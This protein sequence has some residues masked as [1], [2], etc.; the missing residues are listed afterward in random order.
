MKLLTNFLATTGL[1][2]LM[3]L[4]AC[5]GAGSLGDD[6]K[7]TEVVK[8]ALE[9]SQLKASCELNIDAFS[10][11]L[12]ANIS[13]E[14]GP[15]DCLDKTLDL[16]IRVVETS[17]P[18]SLSRVALENYLLKNQNDFKAEDIKMVKAVFDI[19]HLIFGD[20]PDYISK[21]NKN[22]IIA[23]AKVFNKE[24]S[25]HYLLFE[26]KQEVAYAVH[27]EVHL[28]RISTSANIIAKELLNIFNPNRNRAVHRINIVKLLESFTSD[29]KQDNTIEKAKKLLFVKRLF[30]GG[31]NEEITHEELYRLFYHMPKLVQVIFDI[32][33]FEYITIDQKNGLQLLKTDLDFVNDIIYSNVLG[34][35]E[36]ETLFTI[37]ELIDGIKTLG[38]DPEPGTKPFNIE[39]Y[40]SL[41]AE[42]KPL[43]MG[44]PADLVKGLDLK[45]LI[46]HARELIN[47]G[48][49]FHQIAEHKQFSEKLNERVA[50]KIPYNDLRKVF[51]LAPEE[52]LRDF[53]RIVEKYRFFKGNF[54]SP[55]Y[56]DLYHRNANGIVEISSLEY[57]IKIAAKAYGRPTPDSL[58]GYS[59]ELDDIIKII[60][61][62]QDFLYSEDIVLPRRDAK[63]AETV[64][65]MG[66]LFQFQSDENKMLDVN[67]LTEFG[68]SLITGSGVGDELLAEVTGLN[69]DGSIYEKLK[70]QA[71]SKD[72][73]ISVVNTEEHKD[74]TKTTKVSVTDPKGKTS[75]KC[76]VDGYGRAE[77]TCVRKNFFQAFCKTSGAYYPRLLSWL[78]MNENKCDEYVPT[79]EAFAYL[80]TAEKAART[81]LTYN[82]DYQGPQEVPFSSGDMMTL[83]TAVLNIEATMARYDTN[84]NN[85]MDK[86]ELEVAYKI[87]GPA[88]EGFINKMKGIELILARQLKREI[89]LYLLKFEKVPDGLE[90]LKFVAFDFNK[91]APANRKTIASILVNISAQSTEV[92]LFQCKWLRTP[93]HIPRT[94]EEETAWTP[95]IPLKMAPN[96]E[97]PLDK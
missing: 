24:A 22:K 83:F 85:I 2:L 39:N 75:Q 60:T 64:T 30:V 12:K 37:N 72:R 42:V 45:K 51:T 67:E 43:L 91:K 92:D 53:S 32:I 33:R 13:Y 68:L 27:K 77:P 47:K 71:N 26:S 76:S 34:T 3:V 78:G 29:D 41:I 18:G 9:N 88:I 61:K 84:Q 52:Y 56:S 90:L 25:K 35:R 59:F 15:I 66:S 4:S 6:L 73:S 5:K 14:N 54:K 7:E 23:F 38:S 80:T 10:D 17:R 96:T 63:T 46:V 62:Y 11:I 95:D 36:K 20:D 69:K 89:F 94:E 21:E 93:N 1:A 87:Y 31:Y 82:D 81:C 28:D 86:E 57:I 16:F 44:G 58:G 65:L 97:R 49:I 48:L 79:T 74:G 50:I 19:N 40:R 8:P 70:T 55:Y